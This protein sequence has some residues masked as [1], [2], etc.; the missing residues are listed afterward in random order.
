MS[1][2]SAKLWLVQVE[3]DL[4]AAERVRD[5]QDERTWC[6]ALAKYQQAVEKSVKAV[7]AAM[8]DYG[9]GLPPLG[10]D[11]DVSKLIS[12]MGK[13]PKAADKTLQQ[14]V[15]GLLTRYHREE[16][17]AISALAPR[18]PD[19]RLG[20]LHRLN[21]EYPY[22]VSAGVWSAPAV[23][24]TFSRK[25]LDRFGSL[26]IYLFAGACKIVSALRL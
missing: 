11:H 22:E 4:A 12:M 14:H 25:Q 23:A 21:T 10:Y 2:P 9:L 8:K 5:E 7:F 24:G 17:A 6:Q 13:L 26:A 18:K 1:E 16:I 19:A 3:S 20:Q 15:D